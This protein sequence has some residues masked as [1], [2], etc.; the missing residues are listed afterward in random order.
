MIE[1]AAASFVNGHLPAI[2]NSFHSFVE[3]L[4]SARPT[5]MNENERECN[6]N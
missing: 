5:V 2:C 1:T 4:S 3:S 6:K